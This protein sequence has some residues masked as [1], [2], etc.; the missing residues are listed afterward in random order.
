MSNLLSCP[1]TPT[2]SCPALHFE[3]LIKAGAGEVT[4]GEGA[5]GIGLGEEVGAVVEER[6]RE[7]VDGLGGAALEGVVG[8]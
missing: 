7:A 1:A 8:V 6:R 2:T 3:W 4:G 5:G